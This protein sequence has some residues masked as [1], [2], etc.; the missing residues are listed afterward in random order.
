MEKREKERLSPKLINF[1]K[2]PFWQRFREATHIYDEHEKWSKK[3]RE[4]SLGYN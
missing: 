2:D 3:V 4:R 1:D